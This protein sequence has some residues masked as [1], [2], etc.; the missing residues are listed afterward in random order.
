[1]E[2]NYKYHINWY[3]IYKYVKV[4]SL[5][6]NKFIIEIILSINF[7]PIWLKLSNYLF[8]S[9]FDCTHLSP[10]LSNMLIPISS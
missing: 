10:P 2:I 9:L 1:M 5:K 7:G 3:V 8:N 4:L 6:Y